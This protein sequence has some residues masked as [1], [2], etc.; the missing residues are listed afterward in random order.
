MEMFGEKK[1]HKLL[2]LGSNGIYSKGK[3]H[4]G[5]EVRKTGKRWPER[6]FSQPGVPQPSENNV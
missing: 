3:M 1:G 6:D 4:S 5:G 2:A